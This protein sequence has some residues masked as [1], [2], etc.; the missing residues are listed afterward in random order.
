MLEA[1]WW[2]VCGEVGVW[3]Q[4]KT[5]QVLGVF[6]L[7]DFTILQPFLAWRVFL[8]LRTTYF[9]NFPNFFGAAANREY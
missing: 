6:G 9:F 8:N 2:Q 7:L 5:S 1:E 4:R 3:R